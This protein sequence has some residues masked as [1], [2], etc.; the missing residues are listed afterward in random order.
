MCRSLVLSLAGLGLE[1]GALAAQS[2]VSRD[3]A[4]L[5]PVVVTATKTALAGAPMA[6][7]VLEGAALR[8]R[9]VTTVTDALREVAGVHLAQSGGVGGTTSLF[10]R[11][12]QSNYTK[13][14]VDGVAINEAGGFVDLASL[15]TD[16]V[17]R[18]EIVRGPAS[19]LYGSD[20]VTGVIQIFTRR[21]SAGTTMESA[22][23]MG[24]TTRKLSALEGGAIEDRTARA[25]DAS[26]D[27]TGGS[28]SI[29]WT[30][31]AA[32]HEHGGILRFNNA[33]RNRTVG[34]SLR[35]GD[36]GDGSLRVSVR[37]I[38]AA[39]HYPT[40]G[41]GRAVDSNAVRDEQR[42]ILGLEGSHPLG[43]R[44]IVRVAGGMHH[45]DGV[46]SDDPDNPGDTLGYTYRTVTDNIRRTAELRVDLRLASS[47]TMTL[48]SEGLWQG[49]RSDGTSRFGR[50]ASTTSFDEVRR[51][52]GTFAQLAGAS[53]ALT[54]TA[55]ARV[56]A[57][58]KFGTFGTWRVG[59]AV[60][61]PHSLRVRA[62]GGTAF[63]EPSFLEVFPS[64][65]AR[66]NADLRPERSASWEAG[67]EATDGGLTVG[68][69]YFDQRFRDMIQY[70]GQPATSTDPNYFNIA[71]AL[72]RGWELEARTSPARST[73]LAASYTRL[74]T[75]VID[76]GFQTA[77]T[78][79]FVRGEPL[80]RRPRD[81]AH[82][83]LTHRAT[84]RARFGVSATYVGERTDRSFERWPAIAD[85]MPAFTKVDASLELD[86]G[87]RVA[88]P[89][90]LTIRLDNV[91][92]ARYE[93][94]RNYV[95]PGRT[96]YVGLRSRVRR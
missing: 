32:H 81:R 78:D 63:K 55:G 50:F 53:D 65:F 8:E 9:G 38:D 34:G 29:G 23:R 22:V 19:V 51:N 14:L 95:A 71:R 89:L 3:T 43:K 7:V 91:A 45:L 21:P 54:Y 24:R 87:D 26:F 5:Q 70:R 67:L 41:A 82:V 90:A 61:L 37:R 79:N 10:V 92:N 80:L 49:E 74:R 48:G 86:L 30:I 68:A 20:A 62:A 84:P 13:V 83:A 40:D 69:T 2:P 57:N 12:G 44:A 36:S 64:A 6:V 75:R 66:G 96:I 18:I 77:P 52:V 39:Y 85:T 59:G 28:A 1:V 88:A 35:I 76:A 31:G 16:H 58:Q 46:S 33:S 27:L 47:A 17:E 93:E 73:V 11:G 94:I 25:L 60:E 15:T 4:R 42:T 56:D 72:A